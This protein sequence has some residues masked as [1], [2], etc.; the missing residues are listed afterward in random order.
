[1]PRVAIQVDACYHGGVVTR[2]DARGVG[3]QSKIAIC[4][5]DKQGIIGDAVEAI[6]GQWSRATIPKITRQGT[7]VGCS[8]WP[9]EQNDGIARFARAD[10]VVKC[11]GDRIADYRAVANW[12]C[13]RCMTIP[14]TAR[15]AAKVEGNQATI[16]RAP[17]GRSSARIA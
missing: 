2:I 5:I 10:S 7:V 3:L 15:T 17:I 16:E 11:V 9:I 14:I 4:R 6:R 13:L 8:V 12:N 1:G